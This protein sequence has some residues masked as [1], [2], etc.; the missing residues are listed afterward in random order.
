MGRKGSVIIPF[1]IEGSQ[2]NMY[3]SCVVHDANEK[4][5][6]IHL[7]RKTKIVCANCNRML[8]NWKKKKGRCITDTVYSDTK[9]SVLGSLNKSFYVDP[10]SE[11]KING[12]NYRQYKILSSEESEEKRKK[13]AVKKS[14]KK[15][16]NLPLTPN[17]EVYGTSSLESPQSS[18]QPDGEIRSKTPNSEG[19]GSSIE[20]PLS[21]YQPDSGIRSPQTPNSVGYGSSIESPLSTDQPDSGI[22]SNN[23]NCS[24]YESEIDSPMPF[25]G[26]NPSINGNFGELNYDHNVAY[27]NQ[28]W[29]ISDTTHDAN[30]LNV[31]FI[32][33]YGTLNSLTEGNN[34]DEP[35][36]LELEASQAFNIN[37]SIPEANIQNESADRVSEIFKA[38]FQN[39]VEDYA[40]PNIT[41]DANTDIVTNDQHFMMLNNA[42]DIPP[43]SDELFP[44][45]DVSD[46]NW[47]ESNVSDAVWDSK[48]NELMSSVDLP[49]GC[50]NGK[51]GKTDERSLKYYKLSEEINLGENAVLT[52]KQMGEVPFDD[53]P[54]SLY[55][56]DELQFYQFFEFHPNAYG[57]LE[58]D[59]MLR[60]Q[61]S[62]NTEIKEMGDHL[63]IFLKPWQTDAPKNFFPNPDIL[64]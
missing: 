21:T 57:Y 25:V 49:A 32:Q 13:D 23:Y 55:M 63:L 42:S 16:N 5:L 41:F 26:L 19:Y 14:I 29:G 3:G 51:N 7:P 30:M 36:I 22:R 46:S 61:A 34:E 43:T 47:G 56:C 2:S 59:V 17:S 24:D 60:I 12:E 6:R 4:N 10:G 8:I 39:V 48:L 44:E 35:M 54:P 9:H 38:N 28:Q 27:L 64:N 1:L 37:G 40:I 11:M 31:L 62:Q 58:I 45:L 20:S 52:L 18:H 15:S 53:E 50:E 33:N